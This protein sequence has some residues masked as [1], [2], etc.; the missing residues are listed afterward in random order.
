LILALLLQVDFINRGKD[1]FRRTKQIFFPPNFLQIFGLRIFFFLD[2]V[3][4]IKI[5]KESNSWSLINGQSHTN[6]QA[7]RSGTG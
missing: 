1:A 6:A 2:E 3:L 4:Y 7:V 5:L